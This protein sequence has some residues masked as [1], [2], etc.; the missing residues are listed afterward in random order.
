[1]MI[2]STIHSTRR[3][4]DNM[5]SSLFG[6]SARYSRSPID[7]MGSAVM[8]NPTLTSGEWRALRHSGV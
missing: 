3:K 8:I 4:R 1:M 5:R 7:A 6:G 2:G